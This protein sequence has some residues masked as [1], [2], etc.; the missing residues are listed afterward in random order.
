[1]KIKKILGLVCLTIVSFL[2]L[3]VVRAR[4]ENT[5]NILVGGTNGG[6]VKADANYADNLKPEA[7]PEATPDIWPQIDIDAEETRQMYSIVNRDNLLSSAFMPE[8]DVID[9]FNAYF[10]VIGLDDLNAFVAAI[11]EAGF[12]VCIRS[13]YKGYQYQAYLFNGYASQYWYGHETEMTYEEAVQLAEQVVMYPGSSEHQLGL[14]IDLYD[15]YY[16][17]VDYNKMNK[18]FYEWVDTHCAEYGFI[19]RYPTR[20]QMITG[21]DEPWHYRYVGQEAATFIMENGLS[22]EEFYAHYNSSFSY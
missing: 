20:K 4:G 15:K 14:A 22:Y 7:T 10:N 11:R 18:A 8:T 6:Y 21:W 5:T 2:L 16:T 1:M 17:T 12:D 3:L 9:G 19:K 13:A